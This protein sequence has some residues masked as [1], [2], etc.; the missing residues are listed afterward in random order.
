[1]A[2]VVEDPTVVRVAVGAHL[3]GGDAAGGGRWW[4]VVHWDGIWWLRREKMWVEGGRI[5]VLHR[6]GWGG[7]IGRA[8]V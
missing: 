8:H 4:R 2:D 3:A 6:K 7:E 1:M 5:R